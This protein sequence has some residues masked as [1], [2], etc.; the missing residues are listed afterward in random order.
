LSRSPGPSRSMSMRAIPAPHLRL[1]DGI[2]DLVRLTQRRVEVRDKAPRY[3]QSSAVN[4]AVEAIAKG[5]DRI[6]LVMA[7]GTGKTYTA[8]QIIWRLCKP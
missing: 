7:T 3:C 5:K 2:R 4:A 8:F 6:P 1:L